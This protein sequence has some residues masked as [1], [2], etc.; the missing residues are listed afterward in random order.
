[1]VRALALDNITFNRDGRNILDQV[2]LHV[3]SDQR[4]LIVGAN[5]SGKTSLVRIAALYEHPTAGVVSVLGETLGT[6][7]VRT[8][9]QRIGMSRPRLLANYV[10]PSVLEMWS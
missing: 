4:W 1:M 7:D 3:E 2:N 10:P 8:L 5:G 9:R 6:T